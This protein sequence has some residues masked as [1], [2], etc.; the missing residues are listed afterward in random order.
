MAYDFFSLVIQIN[1]NDD[2]KRVFSGQPKIPIS[3]GRYSPGFNKERY[4]KNNNKRGKTDVLTFGSSSFIRFHPVSSGFKKYFLQ[5]YFNYIRINTCAWSS[6]DSN[7]IVFDF[8]YNRVFS[9]RHN[10]FFRFSIMIVMVIFFFFW[11]VISLRGR[12]PTKTTFQW[13]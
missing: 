1:N 11:K 12:L 9:Y 6:I 8:F 13:Y 4:M 7:R 10:T 5:M 3:V 2:D